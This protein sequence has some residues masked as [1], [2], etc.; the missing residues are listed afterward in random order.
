MRGGKRGAGLT[1][2]QPQKKGA[3]ADVE[4]RCGYMK[5]KRG[6]FRSKIRI[7]L[8]GCYGHDF[9]GTFLIL[10]SVALSAL[11]L[12]IEK[13]ALLITALTVLLY[14]AY[15]YFSHDLQARNWELECCKQVAADVKG[16]A[17]LLAH[18]WE[19]RKTHRYVKC[20]HCGAVLLVPRGVGK[21]SVTCPRC[22]G[23]TITKT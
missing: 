8:D 1:D 20:K 18:T 13:K 23:K 7:W 3:G 21:I 19:E 4:K 10:V 14:S 9:L 2:G 12:L 17:N 5:R 15:R 16:R 11:G 22:G 6:S